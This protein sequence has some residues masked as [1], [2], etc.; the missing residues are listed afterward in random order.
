MVTVLVIYW[1]KGVEVWI[2]NTGVLKQMIQTYPTL[3]LLLPS[4]FKE[5]RIRQLL[6]E[7]N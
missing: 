7:G 5:Q 6:L 4:S 3:F 2:L 1:G